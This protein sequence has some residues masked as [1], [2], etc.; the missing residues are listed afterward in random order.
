MK[1]SSKTWTEMD[2]QFIVTYCATIKSVRFQKGKEKK[3]HNRGGKLAPTKEDANQ[4]QLLLAI[5]G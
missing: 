5:L 3:K 4:H 2:A 1:Y